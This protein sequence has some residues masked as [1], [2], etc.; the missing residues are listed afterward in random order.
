L[1]VSS[2]PGWRQQAYT[3]THPHERA[4]VNIV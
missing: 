4:L 3:H 1:D 2:N